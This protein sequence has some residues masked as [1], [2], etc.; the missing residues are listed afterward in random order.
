M[1]D[2]GEVEAVNVRKETQNKEENEETL[3]LSTCAQKSFSKLIS[4]N[5]GSSMVTAADLM[6]LWMEE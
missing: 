3:D 5:C 6:M 4:L 2:E 1:K